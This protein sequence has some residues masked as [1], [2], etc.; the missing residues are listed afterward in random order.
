MSCDAA[1]VVCWPCEKLLIPDEWGF[2]PLAAERRCDLVDIVEDQY[3]PG[4]TLIVGRIWRVQFQASVGT[5][6][7]SQVPVASLAR[8]DRRLDAF[9]MSLR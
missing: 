1:V 6:I 7:T 9:M 5:L 3:G 4:A 8:S 2:E